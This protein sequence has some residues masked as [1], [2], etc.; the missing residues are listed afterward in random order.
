MVCSDTVAFKSRRGLIFW[1][2]CEFFYFF[3]RELHKTNI[4]KTLKDVDFF[5]EDDLSALF[6]AK[7]RATKA[8]AK[9]VAG[10]EKKRGKGG[11]IQVL[12]N[13]RF[14][15]VSIMMKALPPTDSIREGNFIILF[16]IETQKWRYPQLKILPPPPKKKKKRFFV[17][18]AAL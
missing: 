12:D 7:S 13:K 18:G 2:I 8:V 3:L 14:Q 16:H 1:S 15:N 5:D 9:P 17:E 4:W 6:A 11:K 10:G